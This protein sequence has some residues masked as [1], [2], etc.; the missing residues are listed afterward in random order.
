MIAPGGGTTVPVEVTGV[1]QTPQSNTGSL[2]VDS[3]GG[4]VEIAATRFVLDG[5]IAANGEYSYYYGGAGGVD[6][7]SPPA[8]APR[9]HRPSP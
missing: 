1:S 7:R 9:G 3:G 8:T 4:F 5:S 2:F 6:G